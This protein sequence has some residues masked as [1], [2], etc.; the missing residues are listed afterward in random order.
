MIRIQITLKKLR[1]IY[2]GLSKWK[3]KLPFSVVSKILEEAGL[4]GT[5]EACEFVHIKS[6][7]QVQM[8]WVV[9]YMCF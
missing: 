7:I 6:D 5:V 1:A 9:G 2:F 4:T 3:N 8:I